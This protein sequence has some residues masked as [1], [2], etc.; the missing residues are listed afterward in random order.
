M[1]AEPSP[2]QPAAT[3]G[4][5]GCRVGVDQVWFVRSRVVIDARRE[6]PDWQVRA[7][8]RIP[9]YFQGKKYFLHQ[10]GE[11][12]APE[13]VRYELWP[14]IE[15]ET[16]ESSFV[17]HYDELYVHLREDAV[18]AERRAV[19]G[20]CILLPLSPF[21]GFLWSR[22]KQRVLDSHGINARTVS[23]MSLWIELAAALALSLMWSAS[24]G[25]STVFVGPFSG[26]T[27]GWTLKHALYTLAGLLQLW[28]DA[29]VR[30]DDILRDE[31]YPSGFLEWPVRKARRLLGNKW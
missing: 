21:L 20:R 4:P 19:I 14:W 25:L 29:V 18:R 8:Q 2:K 23:I 13:T 27:F 11:G 24:G 17:I 15:G 9:I 28:T 31:E 26:Y 6:M 1:S 16:T 7:N 3:A 5:E 10:I 30:Y 12:E 22:S